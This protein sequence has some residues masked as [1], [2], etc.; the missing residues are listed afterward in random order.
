MIEVIQEKLKNLRSTYRLKSYPS[1]YR[2]I[3]RNRC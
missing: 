3:R 2:G 1:C